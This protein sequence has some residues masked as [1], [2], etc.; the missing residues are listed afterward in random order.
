MLNTLARMT[1]V[2]ILAVAA[3][4]CNRDSADGGTSGS[5]GPVET[6]QHSVELVRNG[7]LAGLIE[8]MLPP[9]EFARVKTEWNQRKDQDEPTADERAQFEETMKKL[10]ADDAAEKL[11]AEFE[12]DIRQFDAQYQKQ[13][14]SM[15]DMGNTYL[16]GLVRQSQTLSAGEKDQ[17]DSVIDTLSVWVKETRFT[18]PALVKQ[19]LT[20]I[21]DTAKKLDLK[22]LEQ[23]RALTFEQASPKF[24]VAFDGLK[25]VFE[26]YG[27]SIDQTL[28]TVKVEELSRTKD[29]ANLKISYS[30][31]GTPLETTTEMVLIDGR[32]Y[33]KDTIEKIRERKASQATDGAAV[34]PATAD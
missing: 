24:K 9:E 29:T 33:G 16:H 34:A 2:S 5:D 12:P 14:P 23:A 8:H 7:D 31:M 28:S 6:V 19:A 30:L 3:G 26:V 17:A 15:V 13:I 21:S 18:D 1:L 11:Y 4:A 25:G 32:W 10:T 20:V 27:F 22:T